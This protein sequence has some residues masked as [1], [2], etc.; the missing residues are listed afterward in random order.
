MRI[1]ITGIAGTIGT[2]LASN[3]EGD[4]E[5]HGLDVRISDRPNTAAIDLQDAAALA[6]AFRG[7]DVVIHLAADRRHEVEIGWD[8][9]MGPNVVA[10]ANVFDAAHAAGV[11]RVIFASSMHVMGGYEADE[12]YRSIVSGRYGGLDPDDVPLVGGDMPVKP[13]SRYAASKAFGE[14]L[15]R[16]CA[17][18]ENMEVV[19]A[20]IGAITENDRPGVDQRSWVAWFSRRDVAGFFRACVEQPGLQHEVLYGASANR[21]KIYDTPY[22]WRVLGFQPTDNAEDF[23]SSAQ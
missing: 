18:V 12:P 17:D 23:R 16:Y 7:M 14:A 5:V 20:R 8:D 6:P 1:L 3:L 10:T 2:I 19:S 4:H 15:G 21:W 9:L 22:A 13:D 11:R